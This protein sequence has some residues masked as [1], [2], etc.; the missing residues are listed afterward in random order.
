MKKVMMSESSYNKLK[1]RIMERKFDNINEI[2]YGTVDNAY[3]RS[4]EIFYD[5]RVNFEEFYNA[6]N[7]ALIDNDSNPYL[8]KIKELAEPI[9][10]M[11]TRKREQQ[12][13]FFDATTRSVDNNKFYDSAEGQ[14]NDIEDMD[15]R[16][17][18]QNFPKK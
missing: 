14:E 7:S 12:E 15:L 18:Q 1:K 11:L 5:V 2:S 17:L 16:H 8:N 13:N 3:D 9:Y 4:D 6:L 10:D